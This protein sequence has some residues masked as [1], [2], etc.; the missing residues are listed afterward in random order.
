MNVLCVAFC[1]GG[2]GA[3]GSRSK[4]CHRPVKQNASPG[5]QSEVP[6]P[7]WKPGRAT[8]GHFPE[9]TGESVNFLKF[10]KF[11]TGSV[12]TGSE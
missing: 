6:R 4:Q 10:G 12:Q 7:R 5:E 1:T 11:S 9:L 3:G 2:G 8:Q